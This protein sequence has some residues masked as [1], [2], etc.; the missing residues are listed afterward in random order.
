MSLCDSLHREQLR[1]TLKDE[2]EV[3]V[4]RVEDGAEDVVNVNDGDGL[5]CDEGRL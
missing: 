5:E 3:D 2:T 4:D 1:P